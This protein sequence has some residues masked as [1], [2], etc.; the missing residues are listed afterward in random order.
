M[1]IAITGASGF[2]GSALS[3]AF[4]KSGNQVLRIGRGH[5]HDADLIWDP[6]APTLDS[7]RLE[8]MAA[9]VH[10]AGENLSG[11]WWTKRRKG[12]ILESRVQGT[13]LLSQT[14]AKLK[15]PPKVLISAS[16]VGFYGDRGGELLNESSQK[17]SGFLAGVCHAWEQATAP[18][19]EAGVRVVNIRLGIVL[20]HG[21][22]LRLM[23]IPFRLGLGGR[24][25]NGNQFMPWIAMADV[26]ATVDFLIRTESIQ[27]P[28]NLVAPDAVTNRE[29]TRVLAR[30]LHRPAILP[31][32]AFALRLVVGAMAD[33]MLLSSANVKPEVLESAGFTFRHPELADAMIAALH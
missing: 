29:F 2:I 30:V 12:R 27:G 1:Q 5:K 18:A 13:A 6:A 20:G 22:A 21:G 31:V 17:G 16:A 32:P 11:G 25:G 4:L 15:H 33:E 28:V 9:I 8:S 3:S 23:G 7:S 24:L 19:G 26:I 10:L 14:L